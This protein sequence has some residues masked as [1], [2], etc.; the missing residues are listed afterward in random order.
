MKVT[1]T[2]SIEQEVLDRARNAGLNVSGETEKALRTKLNST[3][4]IPESAKKIYCSQCGKEIKEGFLC[5]ERD[6]VICI[7]CQETFKMQ[8]CPNDKM[9]EHSHIRWPG[10][11]NLNKGYVRN[12]EE[13]SKGKTNKEIW[14]DNNL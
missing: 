13:V 12:A 2:I 3:S 9:G 4:L 5:R 10:F 11:D 8:F 1:T 14:N 6:L 7:K